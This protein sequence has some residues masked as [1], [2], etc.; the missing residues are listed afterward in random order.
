[1]Y[2]SDNPNSDAIDQEFMFW[3]RKWSAIKPEDRPN[4]LTIKI[5]DE[6]QYPNLFELLK[7]GCTLPVTSA[8]CER[9]FSAMRKLR[10]WLRAS[11]TADRHGSLAIMNTY[12]N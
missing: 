5:W 9:S 7:I 12:Y 3:R 11:M 2:K 10:T 6:N 8:E 1:M 4:T